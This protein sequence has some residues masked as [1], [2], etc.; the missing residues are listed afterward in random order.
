[1]VS[2][3]V[4]AELRTEISDFYLR[5]IRCVDSASFDQWPDFFID[6]CV[7][8]V[9][10]R[11][12]HDRDLPLALMR[13]ESK[14]MLRDRVFGITQTLFHQPYYQ[15]HILG[16]LLIESGAEGEFAVEANYAVFRTK[17][18]SV[19]ELFNVGRYLDVVVRDGAALKYRQKRCIYDSEMVLNSVIYP[20]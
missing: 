8:E 18:G 5:Y 13:Y 10:A 7:Y 17:P 19:S 3:T 4:S 16:G 20:I 1:M 15:C 2:S 6:D 12:N 9:K 11:E 14:G